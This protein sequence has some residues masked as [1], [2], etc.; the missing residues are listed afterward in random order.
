M[1][2]P[3]GGCRL[4][5]RADAR[6]AHEL[7]PRA[8]RPPRV[9]GRRPPGSRHLPAAAAAAPSARA[10]A[11]AARRALLATSAEG[12]GCGGGGDV[13]E[14]GSRQHRRV[15]P[16]HLH[17]RDHHHLGQVLHLVRVERREWGHKALDRHR[18]VLVCEHVA[19]LQCGIDGAA[20]AFAVHGAFAS[21]S[22]PGGCEAHRRAHFIRMVKHPSSSFWRLWSHRTLPFVLK[23]DLYL[24]RG[25][26]EV[27]GQLLAR[28]H[29]RKLVHQEHL[30]QH[31]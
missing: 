10:T 26:F 30:L 1:Y 20:A 15:H 29:R 8:H 23:P 21:P 5:R 25:D 31:S 4:L 27:C 13:P 24:A 9:A 19:L 17:V 3:V 22:R 14:R 6:A 7:R 11:R 18:R 16:L 28:F 2:P 12:A